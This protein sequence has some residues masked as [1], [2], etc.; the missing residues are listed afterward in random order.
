MNF[1]LA[2]EE[3]EEMQAYLRSKKWIAP[4]EDLISAKKPG[5]GNMNYTLR[6]RTNF[7]TFILKQSRPYV[8]KYPQVPAPRERALLE[9]QFYEIIQTDERLYN[10][11]PELVDVDKENFLIQLEDLGDYEDFS[12][13]YQAEKQISDEDLAQLGEFLSLLHGEFNSSKVSPNLANRAMR[14]LNAEH[15]FTYPFLEENGFDL[16]TVTPGLQSLS[17]SYKT[18][19]PF[20]ARVQALSKH[21]LDDG[22]TLLHGDYYPGSWL[23]TLDKV[24]VIDPEFGFFGRSEFDLSVW[25]AHFKM[26]QQAGD[27]KSR[28][29][30]V[31]TQ[32]DAID[33]QVLDRLTGVEL[34]RR[35]IGLAQLPLSIGLA[36]K[37][38]LLKEAY[39]LIM[40]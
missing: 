18:D 22:P 36:E 2:A 3:L 12:F 7:R 39:A 35:L 19:A 8:E 10:Y 32:R 6:V 13:L 29:L 25:I 14:D 31:Y 16:D 30:E 17:L 15:I 24:K 1:I 4:D 33:M 27:P 21:Y 9:A 5:E 20:K 28:I 11:T 37:E 34:M 38:Q 40:A 23:K 26:A